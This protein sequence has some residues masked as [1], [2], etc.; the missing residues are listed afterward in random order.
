[1]QTRAH[2]RLRV[3]RLVET[4]SFNNTQ[5]YAPECTDVKEECVHVYSVLIKPTGLSAIFVG[6]DHGPDTIASP[7]LA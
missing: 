7:G 4:D 5:Y 3:R 6:L 1:M 2:Y